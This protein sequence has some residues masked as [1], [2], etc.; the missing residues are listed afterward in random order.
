M[1]ADQL[2]SRRL[3]L[4]SSDDATDFYYAK[5]W[6]DGLPIVAP[7]PE[8]VARMLEG[9]HLAPDTVVGTFVQRRLQVSAEKLAINAVMAGCLPSYLPVIIA[10]TKALLDARFGLHGI[11]A[12]TGGAGL[13]VLVN[14]PIARALDINSGLNCLG[15]GH[16]ANATIGR[17]VS[18]IARNVFGRTPG[19]LEKAVFGSPAK[20]SFCFAEDETDGRWQPLHVL[21][22]FARDTSTVTVFPAQGSGFL[23]VDP[24]SASPQELL[25]SVARKM[26]S[27]H[28]SRFGLSFQAVLFGPE[29]LATL[30][31]AGWTKDMVKQFL[32]QQA[33]WSVAELKTR[34]RLCRTSE[35]DGIDLRSAIEPSDASRH[36]SIV[37][38]PD[39]I[40][41]IAAGSS[42]QRMMLVVPS[43][44]EYRVE[45][46]PVTQPIE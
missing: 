5:G 19:V 20:Y 29:A 7:T 31:D 45:S 9:A 39:A 44:A 14:G 6:T 16:R 34:P 3:Q 27:V 2:K 32:Y 13:M 4:D 17:A 37:A 28:V 33:T 21:R 30:A 38:E 12:T 40:L 1:L 36:Y 25:L 26:R 8:R 35:I 18:L 15:P 41:P 24:M 42:G 10:A 11:L 22:G 46:E 23:I 43:M